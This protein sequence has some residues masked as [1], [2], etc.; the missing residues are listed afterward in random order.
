MC[1]LTVSLFGKL[2]IRLDGKTV[3]GLEGRKVQE[4]FCFL[5]VHR[6]RAHYREELATLLWEDTSSSQSKKYLRQALWQLQSALE[7]PVEQP[8]FLLVD[9]E[10]VHIN[11][12]ANLHVDALDFER[13]FTNM[14]A[15]PVDMLDA[16]RIETLQHAISYYHGDFLEGWYQD[17][18]IYERE[19]YQSIYLAM[20]EKL[21]SYYEAQQNCELGMICGLEILRHD[22]AQERT[23]RR[24]M[25]LYYLTGNRT[26][27]LRQYQ[28][29]V[30]AL[31]EELG[32]GPAQSTQRLYTQICQDQAELVAAQTPSASPL[33]RE[34]DADE[35][36][37]P[38]HRTPQE[39]FR[40]L[41]QVQS[42]LASL[43]SQVDACV[44]ALSDM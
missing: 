41:R 42:T 8:H 9:A 39:A 17:W 40:Y 21:L 16:Q 12:A 2:D 30:E 18:C 44:S 15:L 6:D 33:H 14:Q 37:T 19:R 36:V 26:A 10:W 34:P 25:R 1:T 24:L 38:Q 32:V 5:L 43:K 23:H 11:P 31:D 3:E 35:A 29:C 27:A 22:R 4:L 7:P 20:L 13:A 28:A